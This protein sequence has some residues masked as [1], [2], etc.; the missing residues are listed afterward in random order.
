MID[1]IAQHLASAPEIQEAYLVR[2]KV[3]ALAH[4]P[5][6]ALIVMPHRAWYERD[7]ESKNRALLNRL[8]EEL[9]LP[10]DTYILVADQFMKHR[11]INTLKAI[12]QSS[13]LSAHASI[14]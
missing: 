4:L 5:C 7:T 10:E 13:L 12:P 6:Y 3:Q 14:S 1:G 9:T 11:W 8:S 2:K